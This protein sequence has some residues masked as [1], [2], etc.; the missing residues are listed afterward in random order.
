MKEN[1]NQKHMKSNVTSLFALVIIVFTLSS[2][3][4]FKR[5]KPNADDVDSTKIE[6]GDSTLIDST[7]QVTAIDSVTATDSVTQSK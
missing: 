6:L 7:K 1:F 3:N 2:C 5:E 4:F